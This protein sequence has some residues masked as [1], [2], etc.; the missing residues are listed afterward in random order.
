MVISGEALHVDLETLSRFAGQER[1][2]LFVSDDFSFGCVPVELAVQSHSDIG[3]MADFEHSVVRPDVGDR[4]LARLDTLDE[5]SRVILADFSAVDLFDGSLGERIVLQ[6][7]D[8]L[9]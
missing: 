2:S 5:V 3:K 7:L 4:L 6:V 9:A 8:R 1:V